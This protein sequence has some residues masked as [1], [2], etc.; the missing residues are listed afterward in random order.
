VR[1]ARLGSGEAVAFLPDQ[2]AI[3]DAD[4][5]IAEGVLATLAD[6]AAGAAAWSVEGFDPRGRA[7]TVSLHL[8]CDVAPRGEAVVAVA[9][10]PWRSA[11]LFVSTVVLGGRTSRRAVATG[12]VTYRIVRPGP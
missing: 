1:S 7:A 4:G 2:P 6:C 5:R 12:A 8:T 9:R 10:T 3:E 11:G